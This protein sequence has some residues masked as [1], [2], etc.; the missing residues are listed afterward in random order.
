MKSDIGRLP[1]Y[2]ILMSVYSG[3]KAEYLEQ[4][5]SSMINQSYKTNDF[6]LVCDG[7]LT[8]KLNEVISKY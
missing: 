1:P 2:S 7:K 6:V 4:S 3:E 5:I 8:D